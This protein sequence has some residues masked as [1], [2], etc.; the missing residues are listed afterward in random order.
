MQ[1]NA[2]CCLKYL[3]SQGVQTSLLNWTIMLVGH[4]HSKGSVTLQTAQNFTQDGYHQNQHQKK[5]GTI[6]ASAN[7]GPLSRVWAR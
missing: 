6:Y 1:G 7:G 4:K 2:G 5:G 3:L